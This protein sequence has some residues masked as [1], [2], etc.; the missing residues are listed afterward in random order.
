[1]THHRLAILGA[2][3]AALMLS[4][5]LQ[6]ASQS[7]GCGAYEEGLLLVKQGG[8]DDARSRFAIASNQCIDDRVK[9]MAFLR[10]GEMALES[11][12][13]EAAA[14][15]A[16]T[17][18]GSFANTPA[19]VGSKILKGRIALRK[20][21]PGSLARNITQALRE[22]ESAVRE[23][24]A[25]TGRRDPVRA[26]HYLEA[27]YY[28]GETYRFAHLPGQAINAYQ[29][30]LIR[31]PDN[32][33]WVPRALLGLAKCYVDTDRLAPAMSALQQI[34]TR[35]PASPEA[36]V[37][38]RWNTVLYRLHHRLDQPFDLVG[39]FGGDSGNL[40]DGRGLVIDSSN[41]VLAA[42]RSGW[43]KFVFA[44]TDFK[45]VTP[46]H[47]RST[48]QQLDVSAIGVSRVGVAVARK[49][50]VSQNGIDIP[51]VV[52]KPKKEQ[53]KADISAILPAWTGEWLVADRGTGGL[54]V[55]QTTWKTWRLLRDGPVGAIATNDVDD[56]AMVTGDETI[57]V[58]N[59]EA[60]QERG[61]IARVANGYKLEKVVHLAFDPIG[62]LYV[63]DR[64]ARTLQVFSPSLKYVRSLRLD[65]TATRVGSPSALAIDPQGNLFIF[66]DGTNRIRV[67]R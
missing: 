28:F 18:D 34:R 51:V 56:L 26:G 31:D 35:F 49:D 45:N 9:A 14:R 65:S 17:I 42:Y 25:D 64:D 20:A 15:Y 37:A 30:I 67:F 1:M 2:C 21:E 12:S 3:I 5:A 6:L 44:G 50:I 29:T 4:S 52:A 43:S 24:E 16:G 55:Y 32:L 23:V 36:Q 54:Y 8:L 11:G 48:P 61:T 13:L 38:F 63:L 58:M 41:A 7:G 46:V 19:F 10:L 53:Q 40:R 22:M 47:F 66:D 62:Y 27:F 60:T 57:V 33:Q 39:D 59:R